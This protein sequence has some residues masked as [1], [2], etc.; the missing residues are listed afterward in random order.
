MNPT[1]NVWGILTQNVFTGTM[2]CTN[3]E[4]LLAVIEA[5]LATIRADRGLCQSLVNSMTG[6]LQQVIERKGTGQTFNDT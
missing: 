4:S 3:E 2:T 5:A 6:R 1:E